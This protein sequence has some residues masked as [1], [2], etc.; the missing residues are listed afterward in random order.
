[1][2]GGG[3]IAVRVLWAQWLEGE[4]PGPL[5]LELGKES[6]RGR[7][8]QVREGQQGRAGCHS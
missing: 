3:C 8:P 2:G 1:M 7:F 6:G 4:F 5:E